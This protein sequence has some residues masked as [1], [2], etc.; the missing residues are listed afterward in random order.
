MIAVHLNHRIALTN[1]AP[2][3]ILASVQPKKG[4]QVTENTLFAMQFDSEEC[5]ES[6]PE[7]RPQEPVF[8]A[9]RD[10][11][12]RTARLHQTWG[13]ACASVKSLSHRY[14]HLWSGA[15]IELEDAKGTLYVTWRDQ[16]SRLAF[17]G[18]IVG[19][20]EAMAEHCHYHRLAA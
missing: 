12:F 16:E 11:G 10:E 9:E 6:R 4:S 13:H 18:V 15:I 20:W 19:A 1:R 14:Q 2:V 17:E 5:G 3:E 8:Y 7:T